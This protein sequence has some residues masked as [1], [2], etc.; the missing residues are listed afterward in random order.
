MGIKEFTH[1]YWKHNTDQILVFGG[2]LKGEK[3]SVYVT[4]YLGH[5]HFCYHIN[6]RAII[7]GYE[8]PCL[9]FS[10][11]WYKKST[12]IYLKYPYPTKRWN[13]HYKYLNG[14]KKIGINSTLFITSFICGGLLHRPKWLQENIMGQNP[15]DSLMRPKVCLASWY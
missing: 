6:T 4:H 1:E 15:L 2:C 7:S 12:Y 9:V 11:E 8:D 3:I 10:F 13:P 14:I 5:C